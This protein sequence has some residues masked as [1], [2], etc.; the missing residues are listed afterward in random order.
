MK[1]LGWLHQQIVANAQIAILAQNGIAVVK[2]GES[3]S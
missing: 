2:K 3:L 1:T